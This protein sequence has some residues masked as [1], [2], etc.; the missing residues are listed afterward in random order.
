M[1]QSYL[2]ADSI[3]CHLDRPRASTQAERF[4]VDFL[5]ALF[6]GVITRITIFP[7]LNMLA[8]IVMDLVILSVLSKNA[9]KFLIVFRSNCLLFLW[10]FLAILSSLWSINSSVSF[11]HGIQFGFNTLAGLVIATAL[12]LQ[13]F[14]SV[15]RLFGFIFTSLSLLYDAVDPNISRDIAGFFR[16][17]FLHKNELGM[18]STLQMMICFLLFLQGPTRFFS[19]MCFLVSCVT[20]LKSGS[21]TS[22]LVSLLMMLVIPILFLVRQSIFA[23]SQIAGLFVALIASVSLILIVNQFDIIDYVL[24]ALGKDAG[25][26]GRDLIWRI[27]LDA[28][29]SRPVFGHGFLAYWASSDSTAGYLR[30]VL[31][32]DL[33]ALHN[34]YLEVTV[35]FGLI[36]LIVFLLSILQQILRGGLFFF[37]DSR[38]I[39]SM[40]LLFCFWISLMCLSENPIFWNSQVNFIFMGFAALNLGQGRVEISYRSDVSSR[41]DQ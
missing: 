19:A 8:W 34:V 17:V 26:T 28:V 4:L 36:G 11:Y 7:S 2:S 32:Q 3:S 5:M 18:F 16:G 37:R 38:I 13:R 25:L 35:A 14:L 9:S 10:P 31:K 1:A 30:F 29:E 24:L 40:P 12:G 21:G 23:A 6:L 22:L 41:F 33:V 39:S 20:L 15:L 27:G